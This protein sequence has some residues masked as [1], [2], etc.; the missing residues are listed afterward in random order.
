[1]TSSQ[2]YI[3]LY[4][5][6]ILKEILRRTL[7]TNRLERAPD[8][9]VLSSL[10][11]GE[12]WNFTGHWP[13]RPQEQRSQCRC[14]RHLRQVCI[15][16]QTAPFQQTQHLMKESLITCDWSKILESLVLLWGTE[17]YSI[18]NSWSYSYKDLALVNQV[19]CIILP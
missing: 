11:L 1:M 10:H 17:L 15:W 3:T 19:K 2:N 13:T 7:V 8:C 5:N 4:Y 6:D 16:A 12:G 18:H 9:I 14:R